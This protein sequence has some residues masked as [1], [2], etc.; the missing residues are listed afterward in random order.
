MAVHDTRIAKL[1]GPYDRWQHH[2][3]CFFDKAE[4]LEFYETEAEKIPHFS[5]LSD[6]DQEDIRQKLKGMSTPKRQRPIEKDEP[7]A[8]KAKHSAEEKVQAKTENST[9]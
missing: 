8:K 1:N 9:K 4:E 7:K 5:D 2:L 3:Q 6:K